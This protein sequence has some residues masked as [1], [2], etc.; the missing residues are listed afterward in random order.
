[1]V[2][3]SVS[4]SWLLDH[5]F[6]C[7]CSPLTGNASAVQDWL[8]FSSL[9]GIRRG[10][11]RENWTRDFTARGIFGGAN[12]LNKRKRAVAWLCR[13]KG[14]WG[15]K[16]NI[17]KRILCWSIYSSVP[18]WSSYSG[19]SFSLTVS[20]RI[21]VRWRSKKLVLCYESASMSCVQ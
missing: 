16:Q 3:P 11:R 8:K 20:R 19:A 7:G 15:E 18:R 1:M 4:S 17:V 13:T 2:A 14:A 5:R 6:S 21:V 12:G 9:K 10:R